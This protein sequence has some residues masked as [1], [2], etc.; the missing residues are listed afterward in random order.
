[1]MIKKLYP[2][3]KDKAFSLSYDDGVLQDIRFVSLLNRYGLKGT[4]NLNSGLMRS[5]FT[6]IHES[7]IPVTRLSESAARTL[8]AGHE[9]A[10]HTLTHPYMESLS[11]GELLFQLTTDRRNLQELFGREIH[12]FAVPFLYYSREIAACVREAGFEYARISEETCDYSLPE[13]LYYWRGSKLHWD[14]DLEAFIDGFLETDR[15][16]ALC[17]LVGHTYDLDVYDMW[18]RMESI[19]RRISARTD[20]APMTNLELVRYSG[21]IR[22]AQITDKRI[23]N[24]SPMDL[25]FR[26][27]ERTIRLHPG[28]SISFKEEPQW[29]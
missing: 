7:G 2:G 26:V 4:F 21:A 24:P 17:Q 9:V 11:H 25:W 19:F 27:G 5:E 18:D 8:Y 16:L 28:D 6:W 3:G 13:D 14:A 20:I 23:H 15:E 29:N 10:S 12:G 22:S 1:M